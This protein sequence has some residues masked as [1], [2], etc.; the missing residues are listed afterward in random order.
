MPALDYNSA[1]IGAIAAALF[2]TDSPLDVGCKARCRIIEGS[3]ESPARQ[4]HARAPA[5]YLQIHVATASPDSQGQTTTPTL[6]LGRATNADTIVPITAGYDVTYT[7]DPQQWD[8]R[9]PSAQRPETEGR[10]ALMVGYPR[11]G[12]F[13]YI[14]TIR[15]ERR[16]GVLAAPSASQSASAAGVASEGKISVTDR[17]IFE[18]RVHASQLR[19]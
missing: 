12:G 19:N 6:G 16:W 8:K 15:F 17:V 13:N 9:H 18:L 14:R 11:L 2:V 3:R 5:D 7:Y 4:Q 1:L 10:A